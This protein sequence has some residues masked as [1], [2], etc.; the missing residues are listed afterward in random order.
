MLDA[1]D[2]RAMTLEWR[3]DGHLV[4]ESAFDSLTTVSYMFHGYPFTGYEPAV[5][6]LFNEREPTVE[7]RRQAQMTC[8]TAG[9]EIVN[10]PIKRLD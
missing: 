6:V 8:R 5:R 10:P 2:V 1:D 7:D 4:V 9:R 3:D